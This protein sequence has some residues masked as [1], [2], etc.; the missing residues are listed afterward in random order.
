MKGFSAR[1]L[2]RICVGVPS[3]GTLLR[4]LTKF[5]N[6]SLTSMEEK[7]RSPSR[8]PCLVRLYYNWKVSWYTRS[9]HSRKTNPLTFILWA[10]CSHWVLGIFSRFT[11]IDPLCSAK[12]GLPVIRFGSSPHTQM[13]LGGENVFAHVTLLGKKQQRPDRA[14]AIVPWWWLEP[15]LSPAQP[16]AITAWQWHYH[17]MELPKIPPTIWGTV[18]TFAWKGWGKPQNTSD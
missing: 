12:I 9:P 17:S 13:V 4:F 1:A 6:I 5:G 7:F 10:W 15:C 11:L 14:R 3:Y 18:L 8:P 16:N 2:F